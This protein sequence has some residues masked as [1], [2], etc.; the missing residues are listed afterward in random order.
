VAVAVGAGLGWVV[1]ARLQADGST[2]RSQPEV[3]A[4]HVAEPVDAPPTTA[5]ADVSDLA[6]QVEVVESGFTAGERVHCAN[7]SDEDPS[8][9]CYGCS[10]AEGCHSWEPDTSYPVSY[11]VVI[12]NDGDH[13]LQGLPVTIRFFD[14][15]GQEISPSYPVEHE[16]TGVLPDE[17]VGL[18]EVAELDRPGA[19][20]VRVEVGAPRAWSSVEY[21]TATGDLW[22]VFRL[23]NDPDS[24]LGDV[25]G[26]RPGRYPGEW[27]LELSP[28]GS[29]PED[30][31]AAT[32]TGVQLPA[33]D[34]RRVVA[35][36]NAIFRDAG[37]R[38]VGGASD[39]VVVVPGRRAEMVVHLN[40]LEVPTVDQSQTDVYLTNLGPEL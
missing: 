8:D 39:L 26:W 30:L 3:A 10:V 7:S 33:P 32:T 35:T 5:P 12:R 40:G 14:A 20:E 28:T 19:V 4:A 21:A 29:P 22:S 38:I 34:T 23:T 37:R 9:G 11:G 6:Q 18:G 13:L 17:E 27:F 2:D 36:A 15:A 1:D 16:L 31:A 24:A 25:E